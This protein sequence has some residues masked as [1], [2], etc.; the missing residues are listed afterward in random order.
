MAYGFSSIRLLRTVAALCL[1]AAA[2]R[3]MASQLPALGLSTPIEAV[4]AKT[5]AEAAAANEQRVIQDDGQFPLRYR[6]RKVDLKTDTTRDVIESRQ[7]AVARLV[8]RNG[9]PLSVAEDAAERERLEGLLDSPKDFIK[10]HKRDETT[11]NYS[12]QL[13]GELSKAMVFSYAPGQPQRPNF[14]MPQV[15]LDFTPDPNYKPPTMI[16]QMLTGLEGRAWVDRKSLRVLRI[17][18]HVVRQLDI[19]WGVVAKVFP[20]GTIELEQTNAGG[21]RWTYSHL[22]SN[23][24][25]REMMIKTVQQKTAMD[26]ADFKLLPAPVDFQD[27]I[28]MLLAT[29]RETR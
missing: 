21:D 24:T 16:S 3:A 1:V 8:Q 19:G 15:V 23:L 12:V 9:Q 2:G 20:G 29:P 6:I 26:A 4:P 22:R 14:G 28:R 13:V 10:H 18:V 17:E 25:I 7:G 5:W 11:R 27:A